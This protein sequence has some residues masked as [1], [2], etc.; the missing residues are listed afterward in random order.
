MILPIVNAAEIDYAFKEGQI[1][2]LKVPCINEDKSYCGSSIN[3]TITVNDPDNINIVNNQDMTHN[4]SYYNYT[5]NNS[6]L[7]KLGVYSTNVNC[8][9]G[10]TTFLFEVTK[11]GAF[12]DQKES[13]KNFAMMIA[14]GIL[15]FLF[16]YFAFNIDS[17]E[18][19]ILRS[20]F[21]FLGIVTIIFI[22]AVVLNGSVSYSTIIKI[23]QWCFGLFVT[24]FIGYL[25]W[26]WIKTN[27]RILSI[28]TSR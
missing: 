28:F 7:N 22:P 17:E 5:I 20:L 3:C 4:P 9:E 23:S 18:H 12:N 24:Y 8:I 11:S 6:L 2:D 19:F 10:Y 14:A 21:I 15:A 16:F 13:T 26:H 25:F 27:E 1:V